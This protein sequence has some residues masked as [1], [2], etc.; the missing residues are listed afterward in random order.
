MGKNTVEFLDRSQ[1]LKWIVE[2]KRYGDGPYVSFSSL[3]MYRDCATPSKNSKPF[4]RFGTELHAQFLE[5]KSVEK[6]NKRERALLKAMLKE[7][8]CHPIVKELMRNV[9]VEQEFKKEIFRMKCCGRIDILAKT[10]VA[11]LKSTI[12]TTKKAFIAS[13]DFLQVAM[14]MAATGL[15][16]FYYI[17]VTKTFPIKIFIFNAKDYPDRVKA[18]QYELKKYLPLVKADLIRFKRKYEDNSR[19]PRTK[20]AIQKRDQKKIGRRR[21]HDGKVGKQISH[22][23]KILVRPVRHVNKR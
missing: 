16:D 3:K 1:A 10:Y 11:D 19:H 15:K 12:T 9:K 22:R 2:D 5:N 20:T 17:G 23:K 21:L 4:F 14:Y 18:A 13:M 8:R 7:L 6:L